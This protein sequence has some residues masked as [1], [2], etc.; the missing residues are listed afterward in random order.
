MA[1]AS[2]E[3]RRASHADAAAAL[4]GV[5]A[6]ATPSFVESR[7]ATAPE[8]IGKPVRRKEDARLL[9]GAGR[10]GDD[11]ALPGQAHAAFVRSPYAHARIR[12]IDGAAALAAP[13]VLAVL[14]GADAAADGLQPIPHRPVPTNPHEVPLRSRDGSAFFVAPHAPLPADRARFV[15]EPVA[16]VLAETAAAARD[17]ADAVRVDWEPLPAVVTADDAVTAGAPALYDE[18]PGNVCVSSR[19]GDA[20]ATEAAFA[21]AAHVVS[22]TTRI[23]RVTGV[24][25][26]PRTAVA[27]YD[28]ATER[29]TLHAG[30]G[31]VQ[32]CRA[33]LAVTLGVPEEAVRVVAGDVGGNYGTR[34]SSYPEFAL[35]AWAARRLGRP[36]KW[37]ADR[38]EA[39]LTDYQS[40]DLVSSVALA[41]DAD[42]AFLAVRGTNVSNVGAHA[43]SFIPLAK[44]IGVLPSVYGI[45][46]ALMDG[47]AVLTNT[48]PTTPYRSAGRPEVMFVIE[49]LIDLAAR[50]HGFD[51]V[52]LRRRNL[53]PRAAMPHTNPLGLVYDSGDYAAAQD[54]A[55]A[56]ADWAG[57]ETR[58]KEARGR[59]RYRGIGLAN[60]I[61]LNTGAPRERAEL[62]AR[63]DGTV[64]VRLGTLS[65]GQGHE[66]SFAQLVTEW[67][68]V[69][70][71]RVRLVTGDTDHVPVGGGSHSGRSMRLGAVVMARAADALVAR[72]AALAAWLLEAAPADITFAEGRFTVRGTQRAVDLAAAAAA[73][74][75][76][77]AP[78]AL[79]G[80]LAGASDET[81][82]VPSFPYGAAV[83]EVEVDPETGVVEIVRYTTVDDVGR[84]VNP[85]ILHGQTHGGIAA[86][87]GQ[88]LWELC[89]YDETG[90]QRAASFMEYVLPRADAF[91][92]FATEI[93]EVPSTSNPLGLR[94]GG[95]GGT[96]PA[97]AAVVN[98]VVDALAELGVEHVEMPATPE[99]VWC[100]IRDARA[101]RGGRD[102]RGAAGRAP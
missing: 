62:T 22:L 90:Q 12:G 59:G 99:R 15:G 17:A 75:R 77:D 50:R 20:A 92:A 85:L 49:R 14:T 69:P 41:L 78:P 73:A 83:C 29:Y 61:E 95:E 18:R 55:L 10:F 6:P 43:V 52:A 24:P 34:N 82:P 97:L 39:L 67:L 13:G 64:D 98:A 101:S 79:R 84:A 70:P 72:G 8:G 27:A 40:R 11:V 19:V 58:R 87:V 74:L 4:S 7:S 71:A 86:G 51:R 21:R 26:E 1:P 44:G 68:G 57:F 2:R 66:T 94:G 32:R 42:G 16:M 23:N 53:V 48:A 56:R 3:R 30:S 100:A 88:A 36:V 37:T 5:D 80:P 93:S 28:A 46:A 76:A 102:T 33:D 38:T 65:A 31:G 96:T 45:R 89:D 25:M 9:T 63:P 60:Y 35:T 47:R 81:M 54:R 91:P